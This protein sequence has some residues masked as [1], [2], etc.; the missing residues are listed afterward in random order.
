MARRRTCSI[1]PRDPVPASRGQGVVRSC[2][3]PFSEWVH[4]YGNVSSLR[5]GDCS[6]PT[7]SRWALAASER[8]RRTLRLQR[9]PELFSPVALCGRCWLRGL[10]DAYNG[11]R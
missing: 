8:N 7:F 3:I 4:G 6:K 10:L 11:R 1:R 5:L 9:T 2:C